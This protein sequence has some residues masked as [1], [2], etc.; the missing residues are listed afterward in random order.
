MS[1]NYY[2][3]R[4]FTLS[5]F[6]IG[7][8]AILYFFLV[9]GLTVSIQAQRAARPSINDATLWGDAG[10]RTELKDLIL[11]WITEPMNEQHGDEFPSIHNTS[12]FLPW[13][14][15]HIRELE[16]FIND[17]SPTLLQ[18]SGL[19]PYYNPANPMP[20]E[21]V[22]VVDDF[23][24][25]NEQSPMDPTPNYNPTF[26]LCTGNS[27]PG[28][29]SNN[30][31]ANYHDGGHG[32]MNGTMGGTT[33]AAACAIFWP[34]HA[35][36]DEKWYQWECSCSNVF[37]MDTPAD[38]N[39]TTN[40]T[41]N[42]NRTVRGIV[43][44]NS[45]K[46]L[47]ING[48]AVIRFAPSEYN[49]CVTRIEVEPGGR[50]VV[51][52]ATL[53]GLDNF[54]TVGNGPTPGIHYFTGWEGIIVEGS[55][56]S[57]L[58]AQGRVTVRGGAIIEHT[59]TAIEAKNGGWV[60]VDDAKFRNNRFDIVI[61]DHKFVYVG[62]IKNC[63]MINDKV[64][65]DIS[66]TSS[67]VGGM[68]IEHHFNHYDSHSSEVHVTVGDGMFGV[69]GLSMLNC[70]IDNL[71][72]DPHGNYISI[73]VKT[74]NS[75][76]LLTGCTIKEQVRGIEGANAN[77]G[78]GRHI[79]VRNSTFSNNQEGINL[80]G[81][82][83]SY[84]TNGCSFFVPKTVSAPQ[85]EFPV[86]IKSDGSGALAIA[87]NTFSE[88]GTGTD[89][90]YGVVLAN[91]S[92]LVASIEKRN[93]F[94]G[95]EIATQAENGN[96]NLQIRCND[97]NDFDFGIAVT[98]GALAHQGLCNGS[99]SGPAGNTWDN[100]NG[101]VGNESQVFKDPAAAAFEYRA[102]S[103][104]LPTCTSAG[105]DVQDC[106]I[107]SGETSCPDPPPCNP[108]CPKDV[109]IS[110]LE[111]QKSGA[112]IS[113]VVSL[114][115][116]QQSVLQDELNLLLE[117]E[118]QGV[119]PALNFIALVEPITPTYPAHKAALLLQKSES[120]IIEPG[121]TAAINSLPAS[122]PN[123]AWL[124]LQHDLLATGRDYS[125]LSAAELQMVEAEAEQPTKSGAHARA[126]MRIGFGIDLNKAIE[127]INNERSA[128]PTMPS[129][130]FEN[131]LSIAPNPAKNWVLASFDA[132]Q[133]AHQ[134]ALTLSDL[135]GRIVR[136][137]NLSDDHGASQI[138]V[139]L[140]GLPE[141]I[142][143]LRLLLDGQPKG[144]QKVVV[145]Q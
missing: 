66:W 118:N 84:V 106:T 75:R 116:Q 9:F 77:P 93:T 31:E 50:L 69:K 130:S 37:N 62:T 109:V 82:D 42:T 145:M 28:T 94:T 119:D 98:S 11:A 134:S 79:G 43:T 92:N 102:H 19:L 64:L 45:G 101:C 122:D 22:D 56:T 129:R 15:I 81:V 21:F 107:F 123:K 112:D 88:T 71:F 114:T 23:V 126:V 68:E 73:G 27:N 18:P 86:G 46:T 5:A 39:I 125:T 54:G 67:P 104:L 133:V 58:S 72:K 80:K 53:T 40:T 87:D 131:G 65:R 3:S 52:N 48:G 16:D 17:E 127:P 115:F 96:G 7:R 76:C 141:G 70:T 63:E 41:W 110:N 1:N 85:V 120:G 26:N 132:P 14:R 91:T 49:G 20:A 55:G 59:T 30:L 143:L 108:P 78:P 47:T 51:D 124:N 13:H 10:K 25:T 139:S 6:Q 57:S 34:W 36:V 90:N 138:S 113:T 33:N 100:L 144:I 135:N 32:A 111:A 117:D 60:I 44:V 89:K 2:S 128:R 95:L 97:F 74:A 8:A 38:L 121:T 29:F 137:I 99:T 61:R 83:N 4:R 136:E 142:Y 140:E 12:N 103:D 24:P 105:V 35:W